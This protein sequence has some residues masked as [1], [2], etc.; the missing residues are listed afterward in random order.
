MSREKRDLNE[1]P[2]KNKD[3]IESLFN[4]VQEEINEDLV[5]NAKF[6]IKDLLL[7]KA[8]TQRILSNLDRQIDE[9]KLQIKQE[10]S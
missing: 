2:S 5:K 3:M 10:L 9:L 8:K 7:Q 4:D 6:K 1:V